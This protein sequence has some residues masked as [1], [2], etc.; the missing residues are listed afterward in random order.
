[1]LNCNKRSI[2]INT[3]HEKGKEVFR[4]ADQGCDGCGRTSRPE[5]S[6]GKDSLGSDSRAESAFDLRVGSKGFGPG[7]YEDAKST[8]TTPSHRGAASTTGFRRRPAGGDGRADRRTGTGIH[9]VAGILAAFFHGKGGQGTAV[10]CPHADTVLNLAVSSCVINKTRR[11]PLMEY[12][13][14]PNGVFGDPCRARAMHRAE[15]SRAGRCAPRR[16]TE[17]L[18]LRHHST[19]GFGSVMKLWRPAELITDPDGRRRKKRLPKLVQCF[20]IIGAVDDDSR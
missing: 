15:A 6:T 5:R 17:R 19:A 9:L 8:R 20:E 7:P 1:M 2:T 3:K 10:T 4:K 13:Q 14:Y 11:G 12:P 18:Y 16:R